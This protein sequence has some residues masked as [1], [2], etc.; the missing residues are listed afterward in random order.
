MRKLNNKIERGKERK[1]KILPWQRSRKK[2]D[3]LKKEKGKD[4][5]EKNKRFWKL[6]LNNLSLKTGKQMEKPLKNFTKLFQIHQPR[7][8]KWSEAFSSYLAQKQ[9]F[10]LQN[11]IS[12]L[13]TLF[14][15][16]N[17]NS[18]GLLNWIKQILHY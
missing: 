15:K 17:P 1:K 11:I 9:R 5:T 7:G 6:N 16:G 18:H 3:E 8:W 13:T 14:L 2:K 4:F 10:Q 12:Y